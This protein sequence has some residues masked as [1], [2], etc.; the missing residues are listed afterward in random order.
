MGYRG[1]LETMKEASQVRVPALPWLW[2]QALLSHALWTLKLQYDISNTDV[3]IAGRL[4][5]DSRLGWWLKTSKTKL[6]RGKCK[7]LHFGS[8]TELHI[9][10][11][12]TAK[13]RSETKRRKQHLFS[14]RFMLIIPV[15]TLCGTIFPVL[16]NRPLAQGHKRQNSCWVCLPWVWAPLARLPLR[17][18]NCCFPLQSRPKQTKTRLLDSS[19][20]LW[21]Q[22]DSPPGDSTAASFPAV[23]LLWTEAYATL[24]QWFSAWCS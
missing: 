23:I 16:P 7:V 20:A 24:Q 2:E 1:S 17:R 5:S 22:R 14:I 6:Q 11:S 21:S 12:S 19:V 15:K 13:V 8:K 10:K 9:S 4:P 18:Q 3:R